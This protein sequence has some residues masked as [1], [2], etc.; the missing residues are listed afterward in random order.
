MQLL[1]EV[2]RHGQRAPEK[3]FDLTVDPDENF[4]V[5]HNLTH[6]GAENHH[7]TG[8]TLRQV[9][10]ALDPGFLSQTYDPEEVYV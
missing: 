2:T 7:K 9:L 4:K 6:T 5:P 1:V 3:I 8:K 10:E